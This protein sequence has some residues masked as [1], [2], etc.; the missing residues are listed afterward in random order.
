MHAPQYSWQQNI[1]TRSWLHLCSRVDVS[2]RG[3]AEEV[4]STKEVTYFWNKSQISSLNEELSNKGEL[5]LCF[6]VVL[7]LLVTS[8][9]LIYAPRNKMKGFLHNLP[10]LRH[11]YLQVDQFSVLIMSSHPT[12]RWNQQNYHHKPVIWHYNLILPSLLHIYELAVHH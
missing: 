8:D 6:G 1:S 10:L 4:E 7:H 9:T 2:G 3:L 12:L 11:L 5:G